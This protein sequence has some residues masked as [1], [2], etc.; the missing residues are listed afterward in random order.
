[1]NDNRVFEEKKAVLAELLDM[2]MPRVVIMD[3]L[4]I[5]QSTLLK[6]CKK[7]GIFTTQPNNTKLNM[8]LLFARLSVDAR[9]V[10]YIGDKAQLRKALANAL[11][12]KRVL[13]ILGY[14]LPHIHEFTQPRFDDV[15]MSYQKLIKDLFGQKSKGMEKF[16]WNDWLSIVVYQGTRLVSEKNFV[17]GDDHFVHKVI[18]MYA[19][20]TR[21]YVAPTYTQEVMTL[22]RSAMQSLPE[23]EY[24][25]L[26]WTYGFFGETKTQ[27]EIAI[28]EGHL[29]AGRVGQLLA[30]TKTKMFSFL[31]EKLRLTT[32]QENHLLKIH[33]QAELNRIEKMFKEAMLPSVEESSYK[34]EDY[35]KLLLPI[36]DLGVPLSTRLENIFK[37][38]E[39]TY[40]WELVSRDELSLK[41]FRNFGKKSADEVRQLVKSQGYEIGMEF[42][43]AEIAYFNAMTY[44]KEPIKRR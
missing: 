31:F 33:H 4:G 21:K 3:V 11:E 5:S 42:L 6:Y 30:A 19:E 18:S 16:V 29:T 23:R 17:W 37:A 7:L 15:A 40:L 35:T 2:A 34:D 41:K 38:D 8:L 13:D 27:E 12:E 14:A 20:A 10:P 39:V 1:M 25:I 28:W 36:K 32:W 44:G 43:P 26:C 24:N 9:E 22:V